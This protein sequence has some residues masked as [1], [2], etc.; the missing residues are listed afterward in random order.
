MI[1]TID[2]PAGAGKSSIA[3]DVAKRLGFEFL[4]TGALYRAVTLGAI[5]RQLEFDD[6]E[7]LVAYVNDVKLQWRD[8]RV[9]L[10]KE[11]VSEEIRAPTVTG[12]IRFL[13]DLPRVRE[14]L[15]MMQRKI[16]NG[17][18]ILTEGRDQ[19]SEVFP[20]AECKIFLTASPVERAKR[21]QRQLADAGRTMPLDEIL[22]A[23][24][25]RDAEDR[26]R[27]VGAMRPAD[28]AVIIESDGMTA[29]E[30]VERILEIVDRSRRTN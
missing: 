13:A 10:E 29:E 4:D 23:Q 16:A 1:V 9:Y 7:A 5:R 11:D 3:R 6:A 22:K 20:D 15:S 12:A 18:D 30:V 24:D 17:R 19:G 28:D 14:R 25:Q 21:R 2:G 27:P 26:D 8:N